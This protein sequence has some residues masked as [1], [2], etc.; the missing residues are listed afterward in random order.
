MTDYPCAPLLTELDEADSSEGGIDPLGTEPIAE[1]LG[2][3]LS[4]GVRERQNHPRFLTAGAVSLWICEGYSPDTTARDG[5][6][7]PWLVFEWYVVEGLVRSRG[8]NG[9]DIAGLPGRNKA[10]LALKDRVPLSSRRYL[11]TPSVFGFH[12]IYR[13]LARTLR[14]EQDG[15][16]GERGFELLTLWSKEQ[17]LQGFW[18]TSDGEGR[19]IRDRLREALHDGLESGCVARSGGWSG[20]EFFGKHLAPYEF[21]RR[22]ARFLAEQLLSDPRGF[23]GEVMGFLTSTRGQK[24]WRSC[25]SERNFHSVLLNCASPGL[26]TL[27]RAIDRYETFA[28]LIQDAFDE[29]LFHLTSRN[30]RISTRELS[31]LACVKEARKQAGRVFALVAESLAPFDSAEV[32]FRHNFG[33]LAERQSDLQWAQS[34]MEHHCRIQ[35]AKPP[36]GKQPWVEC[37]DDHSFRSRPLYLRDEPPVRDGSYV[38]FYR[39]NPLWSFAT[40]LRMLR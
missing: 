23:R 32:R 15:N 34:L 6:S 26:A 12:G 39:T 40:D 13:L 11:K 38:H 5:I 25:F 37:Y 31:Q 16:L 36:E 21:G 2:V 22:E 20:W 17:R 35:K 3:R 14:I 7:P 30:A 8:T 24:L 28:R 18:G 9:K 27:L 10:T 19:R 33:A 29:C 4:P 1:E